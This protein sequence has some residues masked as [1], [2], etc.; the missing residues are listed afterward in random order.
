MGGAEAERSSWL[1]E[2]RA[3]RG[4]AMAPLPFRLSKKAGKLPPKSGNE[5]A[6]PAALVS[7]SAGY[8]RQGWRLLARSGLGLSGSRLLGW[9]GGA[10]GACLVRPGDT[11]RTPFRRTA[12]WAEEPPSQ[13]RCS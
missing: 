5:G 11:A 3:R 9:E 13:G 10:S 2:A 6:R 4:V 12:E 1:G 8:V 7:P